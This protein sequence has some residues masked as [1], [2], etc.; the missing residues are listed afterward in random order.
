M[1]CVRACEW[2]GL[3]IGLFALATVYV[4]PSAYWTALILLM[5]IE[6][7]WAARKQR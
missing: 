4:F 2:I 1:D 5:F 3:G 7:W 6:S